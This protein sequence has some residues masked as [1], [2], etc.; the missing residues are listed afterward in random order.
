MTNHF[1]P[2]HIKSAR[3]Q[4]IKS[5]A[6]C[7]AF[8]AVPAWAQTTASNPRRLIIVMLRGAID[9][10]SV[11]IPYTDDNY[12]RARRTI[13]ITKPESDGG[14][15]ALNAEFGLHPS[16]DMLKPYWDSGS[17][18]FVHACG[19][20]D[21]TRSHFDAQDHLET[22]SQGSLKTADG[23]L[24]RLIGTA[25][26]SN[27]K[28]QLVSFGPTTPR[29]V[30]G[31]EKF[32]VMPAGDLVAKPTVLEQNRLADA[33]TQLYSDDPKLAEVLRQAS[34]ARKE[35]RASILQSASA[36]MGSTVTASEP[37]VTGTDAMTIAAQADRGAAT[38]RG[39]IQDAR[40]LGL[41]FKNDPK[42]QLGFLAVGGWDTHVGQGAAKGQLANKLASLG[43]GLVTLAQ[44][45]GDQWASTS[46][47]VMSEFGR[48]V[49]E[50]GTGGTDHGR[51]NVA[52]L[53]GGTVKG[54]TVYGQWPGLDVAQLADGR[55]LAITTDIRAVIAQTLMDH[56]KVSA[57][58]MAT[59]LP[60][61][62]ND[63][64][65]KYVPNNVANNA[66]NDV[67]KNAPKY[68]GKDAALI[69]GS[70]TASNGLKDLFHKI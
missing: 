60:G 68:T 70:G 48:T 2:P 53:M 14:A 65:A 39:F 35:V 59:V 4:L 9:G 19:S 36:G 23:W 52:W 43:Q 69:A 26:F 11:V 58:V 6:A 41:A 18:A 8:A 34:T 38:A 30:S 50:N 63:C 55:D 16:L 56:L 67:S 62:S 25:S 28:A 32:M 1:N 44:S 42:L 29:I 47:I 20:V 40:N 13:A 27:G 17:L 21:A 64:I 37:M 49:R 45:L 3:R 15:I 54:G 5:L 12:Y 22:A 33:V 51:G 57:S 7:S 66:I 10:L 24:N 31:P 46:I 61:Y